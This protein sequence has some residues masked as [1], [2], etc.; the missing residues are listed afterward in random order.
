MKQIF[1]E[2][3]MLQLCGLSVKSTIPAEA[4]LPTKEQVGLRSQAV[5]GG[6]KRDKQVLKS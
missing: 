1:W 3:S 4:L 5:E 6:G 2:S